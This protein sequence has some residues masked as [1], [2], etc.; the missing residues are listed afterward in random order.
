M[1]EETIIFDLQDNST[2]NSR[3]AKDLLAGTIGGIAQVLVGQPFDT[4]KVRLASDSTGKYKN[5]LDVVTKLVKEEGIFA[6]YKGTLTPL[7]GVG[8]CVSIQFGVNEYMKRV[9]FNNE[10]HLSS[11]QY[12][13]S[14][15]FAGCAAGILASPIE[16]I[17]SR[18]QTQIKGN[19]GP[20]GVIKNIYN[21]YGFF[22]LMKGFMP[23][24][25]REFHGSGM[26]FLTY[27]YLVKRECINKNI[28]RYDISAPK[29]CLFGGLSGYA[30][31]LSVYPVDFVKSR[32]QTDDLDNPKY[33]N[34]R[35][36]IKKTFK[37]E[38]IKGFFKGFTPTILRAAP[39]NAATFYAFELAMRA[40]G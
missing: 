6:F 31:W 4:T 15:A 37:A 18:L 38:G 35:D 32:I 24:S 1:T 36:V 10:K 17:R 2:D 27:E 11:S 5:T 21:K 25:V 23:T 26:Y 7:I 39:A 22:G 40:L 28:N 3:V 34:V 9:V 14:G 13:L 20:I 29:L 12:Y 19:L 16:H 33:K 8:A 30:M